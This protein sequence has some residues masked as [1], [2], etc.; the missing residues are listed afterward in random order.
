MRFD[1][2]LTF[3]PL[4]SLKTEKKSGIQK[5]YRIFSLASCTKK[6]L[7]VATNQQIVVYTFLYSNNRYSFLE[8]LPAYSFPKIYFSIPV[9]ASMYFC[10]VITCSLT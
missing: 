2:I 4:K 6:D 5:E 3:S 8:K 10:G 9:N 1:R 7:K